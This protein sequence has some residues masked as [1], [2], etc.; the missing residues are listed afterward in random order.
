MIEFIHQLGRHI[1]L[2]VWLGVLELILSPDSWERVH[3]DCT[4]VL[5]RGVAYVEK[6]GVLGS[7]LVHMVLEE[8]VLAH[9]DVPIVRA[10]MGASSDG[11][12]N[13]AVVPLPFQLH[14]CLR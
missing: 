9:M 4:T 11:A 7:L 6:C 3:S 10:D 5:R 8:S 2:Q 1:Q 13:R 12:L 14:L